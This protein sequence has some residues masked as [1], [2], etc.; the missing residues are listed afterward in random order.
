MCLIFVWNSLK[1]FTKILGA[2]LTGLFPF[3]FPTQGRPGP[4]GDPG[5]AGLPGQKVSVAL[6]EF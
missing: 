2:F 1:L 5:D 3:I 4:K 6:P